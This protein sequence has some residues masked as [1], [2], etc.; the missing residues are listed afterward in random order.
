MNTANVTGLVQVGG[1]RFHHSS[2]SPGSSKEPVEGLL[3]CIAGHSIESYLIDTEFPRRQKK[4]SLG[5]KYN[6]F[7]FGFQTLSWAHS[8]LPAADHKFLEHYNLF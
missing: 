3:K 2:I 1:T 7:L 6:S 8:I 5:E 4:R